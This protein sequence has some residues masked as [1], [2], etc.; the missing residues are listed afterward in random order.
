MIMNQIILPRQQGNGCGVKFAID[1]TITESQLMA[2]T[3]QGD[4]ES[5]NF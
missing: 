4:E 5:E 1:S 2:I 3:G